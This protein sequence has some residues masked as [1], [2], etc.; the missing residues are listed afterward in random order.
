MAFK[1]LGDAINQEL[2]YCEHVLDIYLRTI[3]ER[4]PYSKLY[5]PNAKQNQR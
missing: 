5:A 4:A 1:Y 3:V 2:K